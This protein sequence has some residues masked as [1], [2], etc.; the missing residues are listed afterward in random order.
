LRAERPNR[1]RLSFAHV[2]RARL[3]PVPLGDLDERA[4]QVMVPMR[5][6]VRLA[7]DVYLGPNAGRRPTVLVRLPYDKSA[8]FSFMAAIAPRFVER[9]YAFVA[10]DVRGKARS[11]GETAAFVHEVRDGADTLEWI[12][13][14]TWSDGTVATFG[15]SY[16]GFTQWAAACSGHPALRAIVPRLTTTGVGT[17]WMY[18]G[19]VF[20]LYT[21][22]EWAAQTW[23]DAPIY[24]GTPDFSVRPLAD[25]VAAAQGG[26]ACPSFDRWRSTPPSDPYWTRT[27]FGTADPL[28]RVS[29]PV[30]HSG[31]WWDVFQRG[32][33]RDHRRLAGGAGA[34]Q[35]LVMG[36]T[37]HFDDELTDDG[38]PVDD[39]LE[40]EAALERFI[41]RYV[42]PALAFLDRYVRSRDEVVDP[43]RWHLANE[44]W[45]AARTWPPEGA[46]PRTLRAVG[47]GPSG[48]LTDRAERAVRTATWDHDPSNLVPDL[49]QDA[50]RPLLG[51]PDE[52]AVEARDDVLV[53]TG[54]AE[55]VD[56]A[57][58]VR[59]LG[60]CGERHDGGA[61]CAKLVDVDPAGRARRILQGASM[62]ER[63]R[64][65][66]IDLG[67]TGYRLRPGHRLRLELAASDFPRYLPDAGPGLDPWTSETGVRSRREVV[68]GGD[69][70]LR[71]VATTLSGA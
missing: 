63:G 65:F 34:G 37:D 66:E 54:E 43:V 14:Q 18:H 55:P 52:R 16:Y 23:I 45:R 28:G 38:E 2:S 27:I 42:G 5:D 61:L 46:R 50:W 64:R 59:L 9:G 29:I 56:L 10:Q 26:R 67:H 69:D 35:H 68:L 25:V 49:V 8:R 71:L 57:G 1:D 36:S 7:T 33:L 3:E 30:L 39:I 53:F 11:E 20:C 4:E 51:L 17:D 31:G 15:D 12:T 19:G 32:Q 44:G 41:P 48:A 21:M 40:S 6:G 13:E 62:T 60:V 70:G 22:A 58:P 24:E 47:E